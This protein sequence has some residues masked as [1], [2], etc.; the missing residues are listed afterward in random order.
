MKISRIPIVIYILI[1]IVF[2]LTG[3]LVYIHT[4]SKSHKIPINTKESCMPKCNTNG[5][6]G[7]DNCNGYC[8]ITSIFDSGTKWTYVNGAFTYLNIENNPLK[9]L[10]GT[11]SKTNPY[12][13]LIYDV[14]K[15]PIGYMG[16]LSN[17]TIKDHIPY[18]PDYKGLGNDYVIFMF[19]QGKNMYISTTQNEMRLFPSLCG[20]PFNNPIDPIECGSYSNNGYYANI[21]FTTV[22]KDDPV[23][24]TKNIPV[25]AKPGCLY[26]TILSSFMS[27]LT[28]SE[29]MILS[30]TSS[31]V[32]KYMQTAQNFIYIEL[33]GPL[34]CGFEPPVKGKFT[35]LISTSNFEVLKMW[36]NKV[37]FIYSDNDIP[38]F[39]LY[40]FNNAT[41]VTITLSLIRTAGSFGITKF[42]QA[43]NAFISQGSGITIS[44]NI[45]SNSKALYIGPESYTKYKTDDPLNMVK[46]YDK[47][48][49][50]ATFN[51]NIYQALFCF[52]TPHK[53][54][55]IMNKNSTLL[56]NGENTVL[57]PGFW[58]YT[59]VLIG[60]L[61]GNLSA[62]FTKPDNSGVFDS[63]R[64][65]NPNFQVEL[66]GN[67]I[68]VLKHI[69]TNP[70]SDFGSIPSTT[71][72]IH[73]AVSGILQIFTI[74][75][76]ITASGPVISG[77]IPINVN[78]AIITPTY[79]EIA[80][81]FRIDSPIITNFTPQYIYIGPPI[82]NYTTPFKKCYNTLPPLVINP[83]PDINI[84]AE[85]IC[86]DP[87]IIPKPGG[88]RSI[89]HDISN[90]ML[91]TTDNNYIDPSTFVRKL[92]P[93]DYLKV[94][95]RESKQYICKEKYIPSPL[96]SIMPSIPTSKLPPR[97]SWKFEHPE[98][99]EYSRAQGDCGSCWALTIASCLGDRFAI[100]YG[101]KSPYPS[102]LWLIT[103]CGINP[104]MC[105]GGGGCDGGYR[106]EA[107][108]W[109][110]EGGFLKLES[111]WPYE[112]LLGEVAEKTNIKYLGSTIPDD[113]CFYCC[114]AESDIEKLKAGVKFTIEPKS[115]KEFSA[116]TKW[117][118]Y[119]EE[120]I[121]FMINC[122]K[123]EIICN[124][125]V[126]AS[127]IITDEFDEWYSDLCDPDTITYP[128]FESTMDTSDYILNFHK[129]MDVEDEFNSFEGVHAIVITGWGMY[130]DVPYWECRQT[131]GSKDED[132]IP[133]PFE[134]YIFLAMSRFD[135]QK[136]W[137][138]PDIPN[139][140]V[141]NPVSVQA[142]SPAP[143]P[144]LDKLIEADI[145]EK[146]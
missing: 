141:F 14:Y 74:S 56:P 137:I 119:S 98:Q 23:G 15:D 89:K 19:D 28:F 77:A 47:N 120:D 130:G 117:G 62:G 24:I 88:K 115:W 125:P 9:N 135:N 20:P 54:I 42:S 33:I 144:N 81:I 2:V 11:M 110:T 140:G 49:K 60:L 53:L 114:P 105:T 59:C 18:G 52:D 83:V 44:N 96:K 64:Y 134:G 31:I 99:I 80:N 133:L 1:F 82:L 72:Y 40:I 86:S 102:A 5:C 51:D 76:S 106:Q 6:G 131:N 58:D 8:P 97:Y 55:D 12:L 32:S 57:P 16:R 4:I 124:G 104:D 116:I 37:F 118:N 13:N 7:K 100:K 69:R 29:R 50:L 26:P 112:L 10:T 122:I 45:L 92:S 107:C 46:I 87:H 43:P 113:C 103:A 22:T 61:G 90:D 85:P 71:L 17:I 30:S 136:Y 108:E 27:S 67:N 48:T 127:F 36:D 70:S 91:P 39:D 3:V 123:E 111:C 75:R 66:I 79:P 21:P 84:T 139:A 73:D 63:N 35:S 65:N 126:M 68:L 101:I 142:F 143:L 78:P 41:G 138:G 145:F 146:I 38:E 132:G 121:T 34:I 94:S 95:K 128:V 109:L 129:Y 93:S 25:Y